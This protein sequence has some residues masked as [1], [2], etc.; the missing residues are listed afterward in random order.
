MGSGVALG[1]CSEGDEEGALFLK[2]LKVG[3]FDDQV[4]ITL[5]GKRHRFVLH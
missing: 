3:G 2:I 1:D 4:E 5:E